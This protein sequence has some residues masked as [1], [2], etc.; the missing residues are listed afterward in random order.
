MFDNL[1][2]NI[3]K[4]LS[5]FNEELH[6]FKTE[7]KTI[8]PLTSDI[9]FGYESF[10]SFK[11]FSA[12][13]PSGDSDQNY[14]L[15]NTVQGWMNKINNVPYCPVAILGKNENDGIIYTA[16]LNGCIEDVADYLD[17]LECLSSMK[18]ED[19]IIISIDSPGGYIHT[20]VIIC[21]QIL[22]CKGKVITKAVGLCAS[23]GSLIWSAGHECLVEPTAVLMWHMSSH[24]DSG[25]SLYIKKEADL[26]IKFVEKV[27]LEASYK[28]GHITKEDIKNICET[29]NEA[30]YIT[31]DE[32]QERLNN[33]KNNNGVT[34]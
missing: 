24:A 17:L 15:P 12:E 29:P 32:M 25:N 16:K 2:Y 3:D 4:H 8:L 33:F 20:G 10:T 34:E 30:I 14:G 28:K 21:T 5:M 6:S 1:K 9:G 13:L 23:A 11:D 22:M 7:R 19:E 27:L 26:Q 18:K 31:A